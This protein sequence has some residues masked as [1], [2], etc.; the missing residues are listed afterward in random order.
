[1]FAL[2]KTIAWPNRSRIERQPPRMAAKCDL[3]LKL[4]SSHSNTR[5]PPIK[6]ASPAHVTVW[7]QL[8]GLETA[9]VVTSSGYKLSIAFQPAKVLQTKGYNLCGG[10]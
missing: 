7:G 4:T 10:V 1:M 6:R 5:T 2:L 3:Q 8:R 9:L